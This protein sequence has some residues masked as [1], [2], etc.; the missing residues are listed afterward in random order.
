MKEDKEEQEKE[1]DTHTDYL[2]TLNLE[3]EERL[4]RGRDSLYKVRI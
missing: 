4:V 3:E 2:P 1:G